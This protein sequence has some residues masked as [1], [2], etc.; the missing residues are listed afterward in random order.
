[1]KKLAVDVAAS[2][3]AVATFARDTAIYNGKLTSDLN[4]NS[5]R[6]VGLAAPASDSDAATKGY[7]D[8]ATADAGKVKSVNGKDG[9]VTLTAEDLGV[10]LTN[11]TLYVGGATITPLTEHQSLDKY[12][13]KDDLAKAT[14][15]DY[16]NV[17]NLASN[18]A[19]QSALGNY[20][21]KTNLAAVATSGKYGDLADTPTIPTVPT[22]VSAFTNDA[23]YLTEH[24]SL[25]AYAKSA[26]LGAYVKNTDGVVTNSLSV[27]I[28]MPFY[29]NETNIVAK[30]TPKG[31]ELSAY[32]TA[33]GEKGSGYWVY[34]PLTLLWTDFLTA[35][36]DP[37][38][39]DWAKAASKP[40]YTASE[41]GAVPTTR[42]VNSKALSADITLGAADVGAYSSSDGTALAK[43]VTQTEADVGV[44][45]AYVSGTDAALTITN[46]LSSTQMPASELAVKM[47]DAATN[48]SVLTT[49]WREL[50]RW[51]RFLGVADVPL[52]DWGFSGVTNLQGFASATVAALAEKADR[53]WGLYDSETGNAA[54]D[55]FTSISSERIRLGGGSSYM[56]V[57]TTGGSIW[58][59]TS[60]VEY[61][62]T[63]IVS[64]GAF[65]VRDSDGNAL[66]EIVKGD[67]AVVAANPSSVTVTNETTLVAGYAIISDAH[68]TGEV[69]LDLKEGVWK[70]E[71][72]D[73]CPATVTWSG[74]SGDY[75]VSVT[76]NTA[77][78]TCFFRATY[79]TGGDT[80]VKHNAAIGMSEIVLNGKTYT[81]GT[82]TI[83]G[84]TVLTL[85]AK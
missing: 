33:V 49:V 66:I 20:A 13:T 36:S 60:N 61:E 42:T 11:K 29:D 52:L 43:R 17:A 34:S 37:T 28:T 35:E 83:D 85:T 41:V 71:T 9:E 24:Q 8:V 19:P 48:A 51:A 2:L 12:A 25:D 27:D 44:L 75:V 67:K 59:L 7:V 78:T 84:H 72:A 26:D 70:S 46:Y 58:V 54:P 50:T 63:G 40:T 1:M 38:V 16:A 23:G 4:A 81:L 10:A 31:V 74:T 68:P 6:V 82:A 53:A 69:C 5:N 56:E 65:Q 14:P 22:A 76:P 62:P 80:Y 39:P 47:D 73:D 3:L 64:N 45:T 30:V 18:A 77:T 55:G 57:A 32:W 79:E 21:L 15:A